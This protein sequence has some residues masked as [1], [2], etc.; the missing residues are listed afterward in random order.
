MLL[1]IDVG[2]TNAVFGFHAGDEWKP[3]WRLTTRAEATAHDWLA[4]LRALSPLGEALRPSKAIC[5]S[6]VPTVDAA[7]TAAVHDLYGIPLQFVSPESV[8]ILHIEYEPPNAVG[9]DRVA[10]AVAVRQLYG[11]PAVVVDFGT[12][13]TF[14]AVTK[15][16][17]IGGAILPGPALSMEAL[18]HRT[19]KL[20]RVALEAPAHAIGR[21]TAESIQS[22]LILGYAGAIDRLTRQFVAELGNTANVVATGG[23][24]TMFAP[25]CET[26]N[27]VNP[28][29][30]LEGLRLIAAH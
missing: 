16:A 8:K 15:D 19:A 4:S 20:P 7:L 22:G 30:T 18:F 23:L 10:N 3:V 21:T 27:A 9:A 26:I 6:V 13:T 1:A 2:N 11:A 17:Y 24:A 5:A 28:N 29:L 12:A 14:D 25:L